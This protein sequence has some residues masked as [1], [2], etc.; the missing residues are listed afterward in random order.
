MAEWHPDCYQRAVAYVTDPLGRLLVFDHRDVD[1]RTQV[2]GGIEVGES[3]EAAVLEELS[4]E[5]GLE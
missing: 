5:S 4:E 2:P 3:A 1:A